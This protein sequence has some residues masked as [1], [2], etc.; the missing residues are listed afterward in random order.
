MKPSEALEKGICPY[1]MGEGEIEN[2]IYGMVVCHL[3]HGS[4]RWPPPEEGWEEQMRIEDVPP[5]VELGGAIGRRATVACQQGQH[6]LCR[7]GDLP[8]VCQ[9]RCHE[10]TFTGDEMDEIGW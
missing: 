9:C 1:C 4:K 10:R 5:V 2:V 7:D 6:D 8:D 3:C